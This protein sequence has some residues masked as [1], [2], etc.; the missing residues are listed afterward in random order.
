[1]VSLNAKHKAARKVTA[2]D[3]RLCLCS[4]S[5]SVMLLLK[6]LADILVVICFTAGLDASVII[7]LRV[8]PIDLLTIINPVALLIL[9]RP[10]RTL[11]R[12]F[13]CRLFGHSVPT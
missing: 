7:T 3:V 13:V 2:D 6:A 12:E 1:M 5:V 8:I 11:L 4:L 10:A 9:S